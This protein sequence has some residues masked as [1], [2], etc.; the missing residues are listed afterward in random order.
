MDDYNYDEIARR[1]YDRY[2]KR[3]RTD[4]HDQADWYDAEREL[5]EHGARMSQ[6]QSDT[7]GGPTRGRDTARVPVDRVAD[8]TSGTGPTTR[9]ALP[10]G[11]RVKTPG[12]GASGGRTQPA[13]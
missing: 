10:P 8:Q 12:T 3:G 1:A 6:E 9:V 13:R 5:R 11:G 2:E 7:S 4:G